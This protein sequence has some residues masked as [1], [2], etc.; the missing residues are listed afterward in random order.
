MSRR[1]LAKGE[2]YASEEEIA[3]YKEYISTTRLEKLLK[4]KGRYYILCA[5]EQGDHVYH[6]YKVLPSEYVEEI[7]KIVIK[8]TLK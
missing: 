8:K 1:Q 3:V 5:S 2:E 6:Q 7:K 4:K